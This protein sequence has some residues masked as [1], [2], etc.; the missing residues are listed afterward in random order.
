MKNRFDERFF[1]LRYTP[2]RA[3]SKWSPVNVERAEA[4]LAEQRMRSGGLQQIDA[5]RALEADPAAKAAFEALKG[6]ERYAVLYRLH[7]V[8]GA[9][10]RAAAIQKTMGSLDRD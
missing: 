6:G 2:R 3:R 9:E 5:A 7:Q 10:R 8:Q 4:L 1:L